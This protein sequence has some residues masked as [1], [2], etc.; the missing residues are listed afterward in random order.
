MQAS[1]PPANALADALPPGPTLVWPGTPLLSTHNHAV[2]RLALERPIA[3]FNGPPPAD[4]RLP[5][6]ARPPVPET[7]PRGEYAA[8]WADRLQRAGAQG[9]VE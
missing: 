9:L 5:P 7:N 1:S 2:L 3:T 6:G 4:T 8:S